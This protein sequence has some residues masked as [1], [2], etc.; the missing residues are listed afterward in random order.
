MK[1][2]S[3]IKAFVIRGILPYRP[4]LVIDRLVAE[5]TPEPELRFNND[6]PPPDQNSDILSTPAKN[7]DDTKRTCNKMVNLLDKSP[8]IPADIRK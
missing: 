5:Q 4:E 2:R 3:I 7:S 1:K 6:T 8:S